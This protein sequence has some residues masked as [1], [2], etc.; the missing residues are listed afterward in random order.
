MSSIQGSVVGGG[1]STWSERGADTLQAT[2]HLEGTGSPRSP[3]N[4]PL[5]VLG[6]GSEVPHTPLWAAAP[7]TPQRATRPPFLN[8]S[9]KA[10]RQKHGVPPARQPTSSWH[11]LGITEQLLYPRRFAG[12]CLQGLSWRESRA[13]R[14]AQ[15]SAGSNAVGARRCLVSRREFYILLYSINESITICLYKLYKTLYICIY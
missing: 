15:L 7:P 8:T 12:G 9:C 11:L 6:T 5:P 4:V 14:R 13:R 2:P 1:K 10:E 3:R